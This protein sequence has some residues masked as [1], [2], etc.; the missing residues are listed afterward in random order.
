MYGTGL[1]VSRLRRWCGL[2]PSWGW[3]RPLRELELR[4]P[5]GWVRQAEAPLV[6]RPLV[7]R[8]DHL[9]LERVRFSDREWLQPWEATLPA[10]S[11]ERPPSFSQFRRHSDKQVES[12]SALPMLLEVGTEPVGMVSLSEVS[13]G[14]LLSGAVG[15]WVASSWAGRGV[16][17][18]AVAGVL[19]LALGELGLHRVEINIRPD[20]IP[21]LGLAHKLGLRQEGVRERYM[22]IAGKWEDHVSF[23]V[24]S[25]SFPAG[26]FVYSRWG[27]SDALGQF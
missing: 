23:A 13:R 20:N 1:A 18:L 16:G 25:Q 6:V 22:C 24:D 26:G 15:Y 12:G 19:D 14:A 11:H 7:G 5:A 4:F 17:S 3:G 8:R 2:A 27:E 9:R 21:S 10:E